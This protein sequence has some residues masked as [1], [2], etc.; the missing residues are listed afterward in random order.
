MNFRDYEAALNAAIDDAEMFADFDF[1]DDRFD[2]DEEDY[3]R[4]DD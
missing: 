4:Y 2:A 1:E 3:D